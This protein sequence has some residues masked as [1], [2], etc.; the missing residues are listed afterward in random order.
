[1]LQLGTCS[2]YVQPKTTLSTSSLNTVQRVSAFNS[3]LLHHRSLY[4]VSPLSEIKTAAVQ[5]WGII[6]YALLTATHERKEDGQKKNH[7]IDRLECSCVHRVPDEVVQCIQQTTQ[8]YFQ[9]R[10]SESKLGTLIY[11]ANKMRGIRCC[12]TGLGSGGLAYWLPKRSNRSDWQY[13]HKNLTFL[14]PDLNSFVPRVIRF[15]LAAFYMRT[16][17]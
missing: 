16:E 11:Q 12:C 4:Q 6:L 3:Y 7:F 13:S 10:Q 17:I 2:I 14:A 8:N 15:P 9:F 5:L 1:M